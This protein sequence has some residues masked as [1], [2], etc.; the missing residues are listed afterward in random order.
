[1]KNV[2]YIFWAVLVGTAL[3]LTSGLCAESSATNSSPYAKWSHGPATDPGFFP[4]A[5]WL[6]GPANAERYRQAGINTYIALWRG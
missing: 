2:S 6:Q 4:L 5:V 1:M 3:T